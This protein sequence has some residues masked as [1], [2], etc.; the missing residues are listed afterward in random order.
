MCV[1]L[2]HINTFLLSDTSILK[3]N[4]AVKRGLRCMTGVTRK[5]KIRNEYIIGSFK[6]GQLSI[7][8]RESRS[9]WLAGRVKK[10]SHGFTSHLVHNPDT[11]IAL[12]LEFNC[13][14][15]FYRQ[16]RQRFD[17]YRTTMLFACSTFTFSFMIVTE[18]KNTLKV[19]KYSCSFIPK[20]KASLTLSVCIYYIS[21]TTIFF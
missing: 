21:H 17:N 10:R 11:I 13:L 7:K 19:F 14:T 1:C 18:W 3:K 2:C 16:W 5:E 4:V 6:V 20:E 9:R 8:I 12:W 15:F